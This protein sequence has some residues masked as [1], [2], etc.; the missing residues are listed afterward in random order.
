MS[1]WKFDKPS[2][3]TFDEKA[4]KEGGLGEAV[5]RMI[6]GESPAGA[7][8]KTITGDKAMDDSKPV[9]ASKINWTALAGA[10]AGATAIPAFNDPTVVA[11]LSN[12][13]TF[14]P[15]KWLPWVMIGTN[16]AIFVFRTWFTKKPVA[17][18]VT[19]Q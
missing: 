9:V 3:T 16:L 18:V 13:D 2:H 14:V 15:V 4:L 19:Q 1:F 10:L 7:I 11:A 17:G 12:L 8:I 6:M 5:G